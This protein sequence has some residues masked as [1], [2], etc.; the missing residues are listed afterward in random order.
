MRHDAACPRWPSQPQQVRPPLYLGCQLPHPVARTAAAAAAAAGVAAAAAGVAA[1]AAGAAAAPPAA[2]PAA[3][4][5]AA[6]LVASQAVPSAVQ[7]PH[8]RQGYEP[9]PPSRLPA[10]APGLPTDPSWVLLRHHHPPSHHR[11]LR[12]QL[13]QP[14][15]APA[16]VPARLGALPQRTPR[17][18]ALLD[19]LAAVADCWPRL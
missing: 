18:P 3:A 14:A 12:P 11:C 4:A 16:A 8:Q 5:G 17:S 7:A 15:P 19:Q 13:Q 1:A 2:T 6:A 9:V 10:Q